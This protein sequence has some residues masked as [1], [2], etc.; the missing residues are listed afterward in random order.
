[1]ELIDKKIKHI[2]SEK[3]DG[4]VTVPSWT[5]LSVG[6][7]KQNFL[8]FGLTHVNI[9]TVSILI[10][11]I[12]FAGYFYNETHIYS[13]NKIESEKNNFVDTSASRKDINKK[14][15][16]IEG[17]DNSEA[18]VVL[19]SE[20]ASA[21]K[22]QTPHKTLIHEPDNNS[23]L[24]EQSDYELVDS[25]QKEK[26]VPVSKPVVKGK[27]V[28]VYQTDTVVE[29]DTLVVDKKIRNR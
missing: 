5:D 17:G 7:R 9:Y 14:T 26:I 2:L 10:L 25:V 8:S 3:D 27:T 6:V 16:I 12:A 20:N 15:I 21:K 22:M 28:I 19:P 23:I 1:M 13:Q 24:Q 4:Q 18:G 11:I 29:F